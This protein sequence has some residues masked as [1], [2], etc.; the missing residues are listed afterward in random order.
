MNVQCLKCK[1]RNLC[2]RPFCPIMTKISSQRKINLSAKQ[3]F[4]GESPNIFIGKYGY[5]NINVG[6]L[7]TEEYND[8]DAPLKWSSEEKQIQ[9]IVDLRTALINS[10]FKTTVKSFNDKL[11]SLSQEISLAQ[12][13]V[14]TE[15]NLE[16]KPFF[17]LSFNQDTMPH[18]PRVDI[19]KARLTENPKIPTKV[20]K[21]TSDTDLKSVKAL[22]Y[23]YKSNFDEH[24]LTKILSVGNLGVKKDRRLVPTR[25]SI[26]AVDD[27]L[28]KNLI[29]QIKDFKEADYHGPKS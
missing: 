8:H 10:S 25:W 24:Y 23:L 19:K 13:P 4:F 16:K 28:G 21:V 22:E 12:K 7:G 1:G 15:I 9:P 11:L 26:T 29:T 18:G 6:I 2:N 5:P 17:R 3:D 14:D 20:D 27:I